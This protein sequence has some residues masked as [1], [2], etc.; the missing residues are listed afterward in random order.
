MQ[1]I[2][3]TF[4]T[5]HHQHH[6]LGGVTS[7]ASPVENRSPSSACPPKVNEGNVEHLPSSSVPN[8]RTH[9]EE[10]SYK[11]HRLNK[12]TVRTSANN[13]FATSLHS[14]S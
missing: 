11:R 1:H 9:G 2:L 4:P 13:R 3:R 7:M 6:A 10:R 14:R 12:T 8:Y 5:H